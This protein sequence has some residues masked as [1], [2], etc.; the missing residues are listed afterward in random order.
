[1]KE[2]KDYLEEQITHYQDLLNKGEGAHNSSSIY[3]YEGALAAYECALS[4]L[5]NSKPK[6]KYHLVASTSLRGMGDVSLTL[7]NVPDE[8]H[9]RIITKYGDYQE[10]HDA[11]HVDEY[12]EFLNLEDIKPAETFY[13]ENE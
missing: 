1:M 8:L 12:E 9:K 13:E 4:T 2:L 3:E 5:L 6:P 10:M 11:G 7:K